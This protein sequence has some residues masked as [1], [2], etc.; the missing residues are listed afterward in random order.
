[1]DDEIRSLIKEVSAMHEQVD[2]DLR[3]LK[4]KAKTTI[5]K[6]TEMIYKEENILVPMLVEHLTQDE[7][8]NIADESYDL[9]FCLIADP[10]V[11][12][13]EGENSSRPLRRLRRERA[14]FACL[15]GASR[16]MNLRP[17]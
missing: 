4:E 12:N 14:G 10:P 3:Q 13:P 17:C 1:V 15:L 16:C 9:G 7:W 6:I 2:M 11:W 8:K 5:E